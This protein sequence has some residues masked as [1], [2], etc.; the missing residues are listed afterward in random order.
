MILR[1]DEASSDSPA[2]E[3]D[4]YPDG[5][6]L[7]WRQVL[8]G[9]L[10]SAIA[11]GYGASFGIYQLYYTTTLGLPAAQVS[12]IGSVQ[13]FLNS[14]VCIFSGRLSDAGYERETVL[15]GSMLMLLGTFTTSLATEYWQIFMAQGVCTGLGLGLMWM[16]SI[17]VISSYFKYRRSLAL[18]IASAGT[19]T[20]SLVFP[21]TVQYLV[22]RI[23]FAWAVRCSGF[24]ALAMVIP[25]NLL[26]KPRRMA[27]KKGA[28]VEWA[29]FKEMPYV[30]FTAGTFLFYW[31]LYFGFFYINTFA[32]T[33]PS[34]A[35]TATS[36][37]NLLLLTNAL[38][39]P[40]RVFV[41]YVADFLIGPL[42][43]YILAVASFA[44]TLYSWT[45][46]GTKLDMYIWAAAFGLTNGAAQGAFVGAL[47]SLTKDP[48]KMGSRFGMVCTVMA[49]A[50]L[51]G[52]PTAGAIIDGSGGRY[53]WAQVWGGSV[54]VGAAVVLGLARWW[55]QGRMWALA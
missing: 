10:I 1:P 21:A 24:V 41:G 50:T 19:G 45:F 47:A 13:I 54:E 49:F 14:F 16:P 48:R 18:T 53:E 39:T 42:N 30:L 38:S 27:R 11:C 37:V 20:G 25:M 26:L 40:A 3:N 52:P 51:A 28:V 6:S 46:V 2:D 31:A 5:G 44:L 55:V 33:L 15:A 43:A 7:A 8:A 34:N 35:F 32:M 22:P 36:T 23:G 29:A 9:H 17:S 12:W 4:G